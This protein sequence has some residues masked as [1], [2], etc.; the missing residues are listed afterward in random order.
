MLQDASI[1]I[2]GPRREDKPVLAGTLLVPVG[3]I[4]G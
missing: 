2:I 1:A 3:T 4:A